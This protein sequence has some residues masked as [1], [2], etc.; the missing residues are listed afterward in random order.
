VAHHKRK[1]PKHSR[2][3][4]PLLCKPSKLTAD[5]KADRTPRQAPLFYGMNSR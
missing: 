1:R 3:R 2:A 4:L 5:N